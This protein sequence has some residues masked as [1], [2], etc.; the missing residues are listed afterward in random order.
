VRTAA[1]L[2][3]VALIL[4]GTRVASAVT[5]NFEANLDGLQVVAPNASP[6][7]GYGN[8]TLD[9][10][11]GAVNVVTGTYHDLL[12]GAVDVTLHG[13]AAPG[14]NAG[15]QL[16]LTLD[17]PGAATGTFSGGGMLGVMANG[18]MQAGNTYLL[19]RSQVIPGGEIRGQLLPVAVPEPGSIV[20][21]VVGALGLSACARRHRTVH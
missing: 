17:T 10:V 20:L 21:A 14:I 2:T 1:G 4:F 11:T 12:G 19:I 5:L 18:G 7:F 16:N 15:T 13:M 8:L 3:T 6:A 9:T